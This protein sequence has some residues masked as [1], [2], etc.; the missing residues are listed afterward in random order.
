MILSDYIMHWLSS[1]GVSSVFTVSGGGSIAL[2]DSLSRSNTLGYFCCHHEQAVAFAAEGFAR[3]SGSVGVSLVTTGPGGTNAI[4]GVSSC[5]ID[6]IPLIFISGQAYSSQTIKDTKL[7]QLG[8]QESNIID[9]VKPNTKYSVMLAS[10]Q[11]IKYELEKAYVYAVSGRPGPVWI[12]VPSD[13]QIAEISP[14][15]LRGYEDVSSQPVIKSEIIEFIA[16]KLKGAIRPIILVGHGVKLGGAVEETIDF[17]E[18]FNIPILTTWNATDFIAS[19]HRLFIG[20][21]GTF[22]ERGANFSVQNSDLIISVGTRLPYMVTGYNTKDFGRNAFK[23]MVDIDDEELKKSSDI[24]DLTVQ[25]DSSAFIKSL[26]AQLNENW[27]SSDDWINKCQK[28]RAKY[29]IIDKKYNKSNS[30]V[31]SYYFIKKLSKYLDAKTT[32]VTDMG[33]SFVGTHQAFQIKKGQ[34][35]F[36]NSGHAPMGWGLPAAFGASR[37]AKDRA[38][39]CLV[40]DGGLMMNIQELATVM[41]HQSNLK[42]FIYNNRGYLTIK[43]TQQRGYDARLMGST[44]EMDMKFPSFKLIAKAHKIPYLKV[45]N[46]FGVKKIKPFLQFSGPGICEL[47]MDPEQLQIPMAI[48]KKNKAGITVPSKFEDLY[49][50]LSETELEENLL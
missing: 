41:C 42:L 22:A 14:D 27:K 16:K 28:I 49:P 34:K 6:S 46:D 13:F 18:K 31:N 1:K 30:Y 3:E 43:Q 17:C 38:I 26:T 29:P 39:I 25:S 12:D 8:V 9:L 40:G 47:F 50:Y 48:N 19:D 24:L 7:R 35:L 2:C 21:P 10:P 37:V 44:D 23:I 5:W 32:I 20:R 33:L 4:T 15:D 45:R 11:D 36:T